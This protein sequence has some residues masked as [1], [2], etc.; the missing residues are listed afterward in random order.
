[1]KIPMSIIYISPECLLENE[2]RNAQSSTIHVTGY[3][4]LKEYTYVNNKDTSS[5]SNPWYKY[6]K[7]N[8]SNSI[9]DTFIHHKDITSQTQLTKC[10]FPPNHQ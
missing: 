1:M 2:I 5:Y 3:E 4:R 6:N 10:V 7:I 8:E 9:H